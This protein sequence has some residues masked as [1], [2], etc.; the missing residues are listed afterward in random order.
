[1]LRWRLLSSS[2]FR[3][4]SKGLMSAS[5]PTKHT[6]AVLSKGERTWAVWRAQPARSQSH[7]EAPELHGPGWRSLELNVP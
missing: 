5:C 3:A 6:H 1:M 7:E 4:A 2:N